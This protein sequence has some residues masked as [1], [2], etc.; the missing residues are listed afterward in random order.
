MTNALG[1]E[2]GYT[3]VRQIAQMDGRTDAYLQVA[4]YVRDAST[5]SRA[6]VGLVSQSAGQSGVSGAVLWPTSNWLIGYAMCFAP[7]RFQ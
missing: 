2:A 7:R 5:P 3:Q 1:T 6:S 4:Q